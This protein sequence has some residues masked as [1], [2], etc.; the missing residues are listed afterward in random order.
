[1]AYIEKNDIEYN[2]CQKIYR[3]YVKYKIFLNIVQVNLNM[4]L[5]TYLNI[6]KK[7]ILYSYN[8]FENLYYVLFT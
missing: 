7:H 1:M 3:L 2:K 5:I 8:Y 6:T 4:T